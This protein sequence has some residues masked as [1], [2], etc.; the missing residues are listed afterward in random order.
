M[1][2]T[3]LHGS[4]D[5]ATSEIWC[6]GDDFLLWVFFFIFYFFT[7][8]VLLFLGACDRYQS[9]LWSTVFLLTSELNTQADLWSVGAILFQ[10]VTGKTP[11]TGNNQI[12][13][14]YL[15]IFPF[16]IL[17]L[18]FFLVVVMCFHMLLMQ[19]SNFSGILN[20]DWNGIFTCFTFLSFSIIFIYTFPL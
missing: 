8:F 13:V 19:A 16:C 2:F 4:R 15:F 20:L 12:Q 9:Q 17:S 5:N 7:Y 18:F 3:A 10:L 11:F 1:W 14:L 6:K